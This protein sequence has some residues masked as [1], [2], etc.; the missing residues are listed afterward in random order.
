MG[1]VG[2]K[3]V[4]QNL[5]VEYFQITPGDFATPHFANRGLC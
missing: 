5:V 2:Q 3:F 1:S 4:L